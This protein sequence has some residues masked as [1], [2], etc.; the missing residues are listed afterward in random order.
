LF[1]KRWIVLSTSADPKLGCISAVTLTYEL[2]DKTSYRVALAFRN[3]A[4]SEWQRAACLV[5][6]PSASYDGL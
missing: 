3:T 5:K 2:A 1:A 4:S 6:Y